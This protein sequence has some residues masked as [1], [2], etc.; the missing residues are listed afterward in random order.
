MGRPRSRP[1][2]ATASRTTIARTPSTSARAPSCTSATPCSRSGYAR[3][4]D[5]CATSPDASEPVLKPRLDDVRRLLRRRRRGA[6]ERDLSSHTFQA[7]WTQAWT[8]I[9][10]TQL[11]ATAQLL[12]GFQ[13]NPYRAVRIGRA[14]AQEHH[15][16]EPRAL[17][18][19]RRARGSGSQP[20]SG[21]LQPQLRV[22][23]DTWDMRSVS[24]RA[25]ATSRRSS[26]AAA[27]RARPLL[28]QSGA[29]FY[30]DD[31]VLAPRGQYFTGDRELSPMRSVLLGAPARRGQ[32]PS[33]DAGRRARL[34]ERAR[35][36]AQ[37]RRAQE[38]IRRFPLRPRARSQHLALI[39]S[40]SVLAAF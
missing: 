9:L 23:R 10:T 5:R 35:A 39:G 15:P 28:P 29:A 26:R 33:D 12:D 3:A 24:G 25:R 4:F 30:S 22:Y 27:A 17:R 31:Y 13:S 6:R 8:P 37:G 2:T 11:S 36:R 20:L 18:R 38:L 1:A 34:P 32:A 16:D 14:A 19:R 7:A 40:L 21:A